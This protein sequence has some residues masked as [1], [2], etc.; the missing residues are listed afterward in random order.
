MV[1]NHSERPEGLSGERL[2]SFRIKIH[3]RGQE[4]SLFYT[5]TQELDDSKRKR[6]INL[7]SKRTQLLEITFEVRFYAGVSSPLTPP[8]SCRF[9]MG[10]K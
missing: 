8:L 4:K 6:K 7:F 3:N 2:E 1:L 5:Y 10:N 9:I